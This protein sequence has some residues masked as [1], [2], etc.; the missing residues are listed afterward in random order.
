MALIKKI[1]NKSSKK[2]SMSFSMKILLS[3]TL[4][5]FA[6]VST[7][8]QFYTF[9]HRDCRLRTRSYQD[10]L[11]NDLMNQAK[12]LL[13]KRNFDIQQMMDDK[14][15]LPGELYFDLEVVRPREKLFTSCV[16]IVQMR[17]AEKNF[18][19]SS[20]KTLFRKSIKRSLPR[21]TLSGKERCKMALKD[22]FVHIPSCQK[23]N[24]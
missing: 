13:K 17:Q 3:A 23:M 6:L 19:Q 24:P 10:E 8:A 4:Y 15:V 7:S 22:A 18:P 21:I 16:I 12:G 1:S 9:E 14:R 5:L 11:K 2:P 20:D